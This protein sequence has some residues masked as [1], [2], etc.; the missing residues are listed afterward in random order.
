M[1]RTLTR[2]LACLIILLIALLPLTTPLYAAARGALQDELPSE[3]WTV[4]SVGGIQFI[5]EVGENRQVFEV[6]H[7]MGWRYQVYC[8]QPN[9]PVPQVGAFCSLFS[10]GLLWCGEGVQQLQMY[11]ILQTPEATLTPTSSPTATETSTVTPTVT[12]SSM[13]TTTFT[14]TGTPLALTIVPSETATQAVLTATPPILRTFPPD[15]HPRPGGPGN[16]VFAWAFTVF[17]FVPLLAAAFLMRRRI[18]KRD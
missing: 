3:G 14:P 18:A 12:A 4:C 17:A 11:A 7:Q 8:T 2:P 6:C 5:D 1:L 10:G 9:V 13:P 15:N 16:V